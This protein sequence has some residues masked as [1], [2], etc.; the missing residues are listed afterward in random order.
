LPRERGV[1]SKE[2]RLVER[3]ITENPEAWDAGEEWRPAHYKG[4]ALPEK[5]SAL[6]QKL[7]WKAK[8]EPG[9]RFYA[10]YDRIFRADVLACAY[11]LVRGSRKAA[12][13]DGMRFEDVESSPGGV[14][15]FLAKIQESLRAKTYKPDAVRRVYI[16]KPDG[17]KRPLGIPTIRDRVVQMAALLVLEPI[18]EADFLGCSYGFRPE[19]SA[20]DALKA[21]RENLAEGRREIYDADLAGYF[22]SIPHDKLRKCLEMRIADRTVLKLIRMWLEAPVVEQDDEGNKKVT[23]NKTGTPQGGV[24]SPLLANIYL[25]WFDKVFN[26]QDG[27]AAWAKARIVRYADDFVVMARY[28]GK[29]LKMFIEE[30]IEGWLG[31]KLNRQKTRVVQMAA[32]GASLNFLGFAFRYDRD[33]HGRERKYLNIQPSPKTLQ[34]EKEKLRKLINPA[35]RHVPIPEL[36]AQVNRQVTGW[37]NYFRFGYPYKAFRL[38]NWF[39]R[40]RMASHLKRRSQRPYKLPAGETWYAHLD[41]LGLVYL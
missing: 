36:I 26:S 24:I 1:R 11:E 25:H 28:Q 15:G 35:R 29:Q 16:P 14:A 33:L 23:R 40:E 27:P 19:R 7:Y 9:F 38:V 31:L 32:D 5:L 37:G 39:V 4:R 41:K 17:R 34:A 3:P 13:V 10:L 22:D 8:Q 12:G 2:S 21:V 20:H 18:F 6:R 30:K